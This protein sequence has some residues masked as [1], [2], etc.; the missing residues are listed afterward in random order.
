[1]GLILRRIADQVVDKCLRI[2]SGDMVTI[3][4]WHH[5]VE[6]AEEIAFKCY[7]VG[8]VPLITLMTD[9]LWYRLMSNVDPVNLSKTPVHVLR[10]LEGET[11]CINIHGPETP[12]SLRNL[13]PEN[14]EALRRAYEPIGKRE[15]ELRIRV[16]DIFLGKVTPQ[17]AK[18]YGLDYEWWSRMI[19]NSLMT[20]YERIKEVGGRIGNILERGHT[21]EIIADGTNLTAQIYGREVYI[22]DGV[23]DEM[24]IEEGRNF[25]MLPTGKLEIA[26][27][28]ESAEGVVSFDLPIFSLGKR[29]DGLVWKFQN[30][31]LVEFSSKRGIDVFKRI[32]ES[33]SG[34][35]D[36]IGRIIIGLNPEI[37][38]HGIFDSLIRGSVSIG[39]GFNEDLGGKNKGSSYFFGTVFR[40]TVKID[41]KTIIKNGEFVI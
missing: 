31:K 1:M 18:I 12:P 32:Y 22:D 15:K 3:N 13:R 16:A 29:I 39:I 37:K 11:V 7:S 21:I 41:G 5:M 28:E 34:D 35:K 6:L 26:P 23:I 14:L 9:N 4:A 33:M 24:D 17:R 20:D 25:T 40:P 2:R 36:V 10:M 38:P 8:A 19:M 30:G 27:L